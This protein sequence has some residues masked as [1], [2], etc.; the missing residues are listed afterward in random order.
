[1]RYNDVAIAELPE[2]VQNGAGAG[3]PFDMFKGGFIR[4]TSVISAGNVSLW[5][6][7]SAAFSL[8]INK[9]QMSLEYVPF[10]IVNP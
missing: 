9:L 3:N 7:A 10:S 2:W 8:L 4:D 1:M 6:K 5:I